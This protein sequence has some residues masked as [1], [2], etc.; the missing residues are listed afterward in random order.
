MAAAFELT[1]LG[2]SSATPTS[3]RHPTAQLLNVAERFFLIDC[4][5]ATQ[6]QLRKYKIRFQRIDHIFISHLHGDHY[7]GLMG[8]LSSLHL[9][10]RKKELTI[11]HPPGLKTIID[12]QFE[13]S[14]TVLNY[15]INWHE[16]D[17][18]KAG[19]IFEDHVLSV[20]T[21]LLNH[22]IPCCG[23]IFREKE[24]MFSLDKEK[25]AEY[26][27]S[28][29]F[30]SDLKNGKDIMPDGMRKF[31]NEELTKGRYASRSYA[32]VSDT[33]YNEKVIEAVKDVDLLYH[34]STFLHEMLERAEKTFHTTALEAGLAAK[35][36]G[37]KKLVIGHFSVRYTDLLPLLEEARTEFP[38]TQLAEEGTKFTIPEV[39]LVNK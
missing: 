36:A 2:S 33:R 5:E 7:L 32:F 16:H 25:L 4:G 26:G 24:K 10:G 37:V 17:I 29:E 35:K 8:L 31:R 13:L 39:F 30:F 34:E 21:V 1:I 6:I 38:Q 19:I 11:Y 9:L 23:F 20:E 22:R 14:G 18:H 3:K 15:K 12:L 28:R 27:I